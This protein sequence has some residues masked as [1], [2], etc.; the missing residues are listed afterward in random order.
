[1]EVQYGKFLAVTV[2][3]G[4]IDKWL[5]YL[6]YLRDQIGLFRVC[7]GRLR[8]AGGDGLSRGS[9]IWDCHAEMAML[10]WDCYAQMREHVLLGEEVIRAMKK[11]RTLT[12]VE[13]AEFMKSG[14][15]VL[16][17]DWVPWEESDGEPYTRSMLIDIRGDGS[18][19]R[20]YEV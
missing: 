9:L 15:C 17:T 4:C 2:L 16:E 3:D 13:M 11:V 7:V 18:R 14:D 8:S 12:G 6:Q 1:M 20:P 19:G 10:I 5:D